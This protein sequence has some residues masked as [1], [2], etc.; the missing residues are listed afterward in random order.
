MCSAQQGD[1]LNLRNLRT[2]WYQLQSF[3]EVF[4]QRSKC[5]YEYLG[6]HIPHPVNFD[7]QILVLDNFYSFFKR[8]GEN[9]LPSQLHAFFFKPA[10]PV[11]TLLNIITQ[12]DHATAVSRHQLNKTPT[13]IAPLNVQPTN[14]SF[15]MVKEYVHD[16]W[17]AQKGFCKPVFA[18]TT[19]RD[20]FVSIKRYLRFDDLAT[21]LQRRQGDISWPQ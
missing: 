10:K 6:F 14:I 18:A 11:F 21:R 4:S 8:S 19:R 20:R 17:S 12:T 13:S 16:V 2:S 9:I 1:F 15:R 5:S 7:L 3:R